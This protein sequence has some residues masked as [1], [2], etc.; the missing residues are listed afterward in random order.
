MTPPA[1]AAEENRWAGVTM[2]MMMGGGGSGKGSAAAAAVGLRSHRNF[3]AARS[4]AGDWIV[5]KKLTAG[6]RK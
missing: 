2:T 6:G 4:G 1:G 5:G 3:T